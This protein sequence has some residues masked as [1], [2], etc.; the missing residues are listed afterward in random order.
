VK[1]APPENLEIVDPKDRCFPPSWRD[2]AIRRLFDDVRDGIKCP[3]CHEWFRG[4]RE[5]KLL[6]ADHIVPWSKGG[7]TTWENLHILCGPCNVEKSAGS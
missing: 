1:G 5:L 3:H 2:A 6:H 4:R 7:F